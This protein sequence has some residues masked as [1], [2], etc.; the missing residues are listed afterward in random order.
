M[1]RDREGDEKER[2]EALDLLRKQMAVEGQLIRLYEETEGQ[3]ESGAVRHVLH[4]VQLDSR[5]HID[6]LQLVIDVLQGEDVLK[7]ERDEVIN[8]LR[9]HV[10][11][12]KEALDSANRL[13]D[14]IWIRETK[15]LEELVKKWRNDEK[16]HVRML[17]EIMVR[18]FFRLGSHDLTTSLR[19]TEELEERYV[20]YERKK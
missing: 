6:I 3:I 12:E 13:L 4:M 7:R 14:N 19:T 20:K 8:G 11:L 5:K 18:P 1:G 10:E 9:R 2:R 17:N 16:E 15:G